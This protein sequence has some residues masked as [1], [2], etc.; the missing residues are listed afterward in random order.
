MASSAPLSPAGKPMKFSIRDEPPAWPPG[1]SRSSIKVLRPSEAGIDS[2]RNSGRATPDNCKIN[3]LEGQC[4]QMPASS[5]SSVRM[6]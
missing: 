5:A 4:C 3:V 2:R 6:G 1:P